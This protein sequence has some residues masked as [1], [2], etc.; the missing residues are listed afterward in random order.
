MGAVCFPLILC[1][2]GLFVDPIPHDH[3]R[4]LYLLVLTCAFRRFQ[5]LDDWRFTVANGSRCHVRRFSKVGADM[6]CERLNF[7]TRIHGLCQRHHLPALP[8][9]P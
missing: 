1:L 2:G 7:H 6:A 4:S 3:L 8:L 5:N 9:V